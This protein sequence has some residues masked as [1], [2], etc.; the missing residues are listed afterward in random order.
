M[1]DNDTASA[2]VDNMNKFDFPQDDI[3]SDDGCEYKKLEG[4][5]GFTYLLSSL[6][7]LALSSLW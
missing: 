7:K 3:Q 2:G 5:P 4:F 1:G 6:L